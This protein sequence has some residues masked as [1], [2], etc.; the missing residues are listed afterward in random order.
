M[1]KSMRLFMLLVTLIAQLKKLRV[2]PKKLLR[3][4]AENVDKL[5]A[6]TRYYPKAV[7]SGGMYRGSETDTLTFGVVITTTSSLSAPVAYQVVKSV[8]ENHDEFIQ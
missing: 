1:I 3:V 2:L 6:A 5:T 7:I 4:S 8:F